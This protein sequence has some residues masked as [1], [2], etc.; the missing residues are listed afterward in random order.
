MTT[1][2]SPAQQ[3][4]LSHAETTAKLAATIAN[5][6]LLHEKRPVRV[7]FVQRRNF[8]VSGRVGVDSKVVDYPDEDA[9]QLIDDMARYH[10]ERGGKPLCYA[11][12]KPPGYP[13]VVRRELP[14]D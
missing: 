13:S 9:A 14:L 7:S 2:L 3:W 5:K 8:E 4:R 6:F 11:K 1:E 12:R 10:V